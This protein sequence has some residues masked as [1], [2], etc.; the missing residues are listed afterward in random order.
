MQRR[1]SRKRA[2][3]RRIR[4]IDLRGGAPETLG[5]T[6]KN[7]YTS[8]GP[9][10]I[11]LLIIALFAPS[12]SEA[13]KSDI[14]LTREVS[15]QE[16]YVKLTEE[17][18]VLRRERRILTDTIA[19]LRMRNSALMSRV[20]DLE[21]TVRELRSGVAEKDEM[22]KKERDLAEG[23]IEEI[24]KELKSALE[25]EQKIEQDRG[26]QAYAR[27]YNETREELKEAKQQISGLLRQLREEER[28][29]KKIVADLSKETRELRTRVGK[30]HFNLATLLFRQGEYKKAEYE[31]EQAE[32]FTPTDSEILYNIA[33]LNDYYLDNPE[34][35]NEYYA[36][37]LET[38]RNPRDR[39]KIAERMAEKSLQALMNKHKID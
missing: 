28:T 33:V 30:A 10:L 37:Y 20:K 38:E 8:R 25:Q 39:K 23:R 29:S 12:P 15:L 14:A 9:A 34:K 32:K 1:C 24:K 18:A 36:R 21:D 5:I 19:E 31:Y 11:F 4:C 22:I 27:R 3:S 7:V 16:S 13:E 17:M 26:R 2:L 6:G 35:S